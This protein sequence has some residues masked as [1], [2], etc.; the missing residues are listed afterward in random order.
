[1]MGRG[2]GAF[3]DANKILVGLVVEQ[4]KQ[5]QREKDSN[6]NPSNNGSRH[7]H[8]CEKSCDG[9]YTSP[10][11]SKNHQHGVPL[12]LESVLPRVRG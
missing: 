8:G 6:E 7:S 11:V 9:Y 2:V 10:G 4:N 3:Q 5:C 1:M 12:P